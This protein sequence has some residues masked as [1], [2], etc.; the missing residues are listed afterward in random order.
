MST[1]NA[2]HEDGGNLFLKCKYARAVWRELLMENL[3]VDLANQ[4]SPLEVLWKI[5]QWSLKCQVRVITT[6]WRIWSHLND[7]NTGEA[8][9]S[10]SATTSAAVRYYTEYI[11]HYEIPKPINTPV[12]SWKAPPAELPE[13]ECG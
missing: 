10:L 13:V 6:L 2:L 12:H 4:R 11:D 7:V 5:W 3:R 1:Q 8:M 9:I